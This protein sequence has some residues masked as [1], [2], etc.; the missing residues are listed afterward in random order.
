MPLAGVLVFAAGWGGTSCSRFESCADTSTCRGKDAG[1]RST[2]LADSSA[3]DASV[4]QDA[5]SRSSVDAGSPGLPP[6]DASS[7]EYR[8]AD[9]GCRDGFADC[10]GNAR[11]GCEANLGEDIENCGACGHACGNDGT[12]SLA[13]TAGRCTPTC[14]DGRADCHTP[15]PGEDDDG[16][17]AHT[18]IDKDHCGACDHA[19]SQANVT[20][21]SCVA[22]ACVPTCA[23]GWADCVRPATDPD[24]GCEASLD[25]PRSCGACGMSCETGACTNRL[26][27]PVVLAESA[28]PSTLSG[29]TFDG[30]GASGVAIDEKYVY[31]V[32]ASE[33]AVSRVP[34]AGGA[35]EPLATGETNAAGV[36]VTALGLYFTAQ[37][38]GNGA[39]RYRLLSAPDVTNFWVPAQNDTKRYAPTRIAVDGTYA[40]WGSADGETVFTEPLSQTN[41]WSRP[42]P[43]PVNALA[44]GGGYVFYTAGAVFRSPLDATTTTIVDINT[45]STLTVD[46]SWVYWADNSSYAI[47]REPVDADPTD[48]SVVQHV[49]GGHAHQ[50]VV[51]GGRDVWYA[52]FSN[53]LTA[54]QLYT[55]VLPASG[56]GNPVKRASCG[57]VLGMAADA[58]HVYWVENGTAGGFR[59]MKL[60]K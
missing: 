22:G 24:D 16:C 54:D 59:V 56:V 7:S 33:G 17:E 34:K 51:Y 37:S 32:H 19:C 41:R 35:V 15:A 4:A 52:A 29:G 26:C 44:I 48:P 11:N 13:C 28:K 43:F 9:G 57:S 39:V 40:A 5:G 60:V 18:Q 1:A 46:G 42:T 58:T 53:D 47:N 6:K 3:P 20:A 23:D 2:G 25:D 31:F 10:D 49:G 30:N 36:A 12:T 45:P 38:N 27:G 50:M 14:A 21:R 55:F 8:N